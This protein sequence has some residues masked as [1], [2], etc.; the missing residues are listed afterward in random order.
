[1]AKRKVKDLEDDVPAEEPRR[2][3]RRVSTAREEITP[4]KLKPAPAVKTAKKV[5]KP[6]KVVSPT[7]NSEESKSSDTVSPWKSISIFPT[8]CSPEDNASALPFIPCH[9]ADIT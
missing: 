9:V 5:K 6:V 4:D 2:S 3:S 1:M 7:V 8:S